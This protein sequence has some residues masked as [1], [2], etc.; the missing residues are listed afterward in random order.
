MLVVALVRAAVLR[1]AGGGAVTGAA[2][3]GRVPVRGCAVVAAGVVVNLCLGMLYAWSVWKATLAPKGVAPGT[4][5]VGLNDGWVTLSDAQA[6]W[7]YAVCGLTFAAVMVPG[8]RLQDRHG[9]RA[10][11][12][13]AGLCLALGC[14]VAGLLKSYLGLI[15][16]FG[17]LGGAGLGLM[18]F[19]WFA[20][21]DP[22]IGIGFIPL[23]IGVGQLIAW[24][25][26]QGRKDG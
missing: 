16:G 3:A 26:E 11:A 24:K 17:L 15:L 14:A 5:M 9:P 19:F 2:G 7:A 25:I 18:G 8:G 10:G 21:A 22:A 13:L 6:T 12:V 20:G 4:P 23:M 1:G